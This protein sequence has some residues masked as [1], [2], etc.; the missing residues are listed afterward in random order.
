VKETWTFTNADGTP[1]TTNF[2]ILT[3]ATF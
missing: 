2:D 3:N 1:T